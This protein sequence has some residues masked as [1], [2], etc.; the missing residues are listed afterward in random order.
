[1][2]GGRRLAYVSVAL[3]FAIA[4]I[5][6]VTADDDTAGDEPA[7][8]APVTDPKVAKRWLTTA[9]QL[10]AKGDAATRAKQP[11][12]ARTQYDNA[13]T[14]YEKAIEAGADATAL[15][16]LGTVYEKLGKP[17][18]AAVHYRTAMTATGAR[19]DLVK[20]ATARLEDVAMKVGFV[21]LEI[22]PPGTT[23]TIEDEQVGTTPLAEPLV[24]LPGTYSLTLAAEGHQ[25]RTVEIK[26]EAGSESERSYTLEVQQGAPPPVK[27]DDSELVDSPRAVTARGPSKAPLVVSGGLAVGFATVATVT[28]LLAVGKHGTFDDAAST[29]DERADA[30]ASGE[31]LALITDVCI[32]GAVVAGGFATYWYF[33]KYRPARRTR[34][35]ERQAGTVRTAP[36]AAAKVDVVPWVKPGGGG[37]VLAGRF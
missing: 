27:R 11:D 25:S 14:A 32:A 21:M 3:A 7:A 13:V 24:L 4:P 26:V 37:F 28:G 35:L 22:T 9:Q 33:A 10:V 16:E 12:A 30:K 19:P 5:G 23:I 8:T 31:R 36:L 15:F 29:P 1:M 17:R 20:K 34:T 2:G 6:T 18:L